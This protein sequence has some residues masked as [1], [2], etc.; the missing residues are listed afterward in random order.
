LPNQ[1]G[2]YGN[3][4]TNYVDG[5]DND[6]INGR[7]D[8]NVSDRQH[9]F[10]RYTHWSIY[11]IPYHGLGN[12]KDDST[13][14]VL[15]SLS[16]Q[17]VLGDTYAINPSTVLDVRASYMRYGWFDESDTTGID[18]TTLGFPAYMNS[19]PR[20]MSPQP[21]IN[22]FSGWGCWGS[23][24]IG[25]NQDFSFSGNLT[26]IRGKHTL[27]V[28]TEIRKM[29][30]SYAQNNYSSGAFF[31][32]NGM[33]SQNPLNPGGTGFSYASFMLGY[34]AISNPTYGPSSECIQA[35]TPP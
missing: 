23:F 35:L 30:D 12:V 7:I 29:D 22:G 8:Q 11:Q 26:K 25:A 21:C 14:F 28:G 34:G 33:T 19:L 10:G 6:Q 31:F 15:H 32:D 3:F 4:I 27:K 13:G 18:A 24:Y 1:P 20:R 16:Q 2:L 5:G 17:F 9:I